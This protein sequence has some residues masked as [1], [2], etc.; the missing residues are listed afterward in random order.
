MKTAVEIETRIKAVDGGAPIPC[1]RQLRA[2]KD[3]IRAV[4][5]LTVPENLA[6]HIRSETAIGMN[7]APTSAVASP[8]YP[9]PLRPGRVG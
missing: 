3:V 4:T 5:G 1:V 8:A 2:S 6:I 9:D 7:R